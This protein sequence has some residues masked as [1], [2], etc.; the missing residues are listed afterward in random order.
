MKYFSMFDKKSGAYNPTIFAATSIAEAVRSVQMHLEEGKSPVAKF[1]ADFKLCL[2]GDFDPANGLM[3]PPTAQGPI[4][5]QEVSAMMSDM[6]LA[7]NP[8]TTP[9]AKKEVM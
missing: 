6:L 1:P 4:D 7:R 2:V 9:V 8:P 3:T 5:V